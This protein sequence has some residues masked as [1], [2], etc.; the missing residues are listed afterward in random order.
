MIN[1]SNQ[2]KR[3]TVTDKEVIEFL[4]YIEEKLENDAEK[5]QSFMEIFSKLNNSTYIF[6]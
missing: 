5:L 6:K 1:T 2:I 3:K 4:V